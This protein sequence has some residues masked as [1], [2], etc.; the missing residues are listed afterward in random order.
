MAEAHKP[1]RVAVNVMRARQTVVGFNIAVLS[2]QI[3]QMAR[4]PGGLKVSGMEHA[5]HLRADLALFMA[6]A[7]ALLSLLAL[8]L[9]SDF[10]EVGYCTRW[11]LVAGD[12]LMYLS[13]AHTVT[14]FFEPLD[15]AIGLFTARIPAQADEMAILQ[16]GMRIAAGAAWFLATYAGP[17][18][19]LK[20]SPFPRRINIALGIG[21][22]IL[23]V[24]LCWVGALA[25][26]VETV[27]GGA[28]LTMMSGILGEMIQP[29]RW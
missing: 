21:Y 14:G 19:A 16:T 2:I 3:A 26:R 9:S 8:T 18:M 5:V 27:N 12:I 25:L 10:D 22:L 17:V 7:L 4:L 11:T 29:F 15:A 1:V 28:P 13:L 20:Q 6:L 23:L 24:A